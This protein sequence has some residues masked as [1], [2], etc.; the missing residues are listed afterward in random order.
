MRLKLNGQVLASA[1]DV[2]LWTPQPGA[3]RLE[4]EAPG[5]RL[6]DQILFTV[7]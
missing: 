2:T 4:L 3:Y 1:Q 5:G 6:L 7:R